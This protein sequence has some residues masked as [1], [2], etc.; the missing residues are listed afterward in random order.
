M[1]G[2]GPP[3]NQGANLGI[4]VKHGKLPLGPGAAQRQQSIELGLE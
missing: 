4:V 1:D 3:L 2:A